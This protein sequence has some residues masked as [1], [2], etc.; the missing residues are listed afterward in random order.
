MSGFWN[1]AKNRFIYDTLFTGNGKTAEQ[2]RAEKE[3]SDEVD[4]NIE[5]RLKMSDEE[6]AAEDAFLDAYF[7]RQEEELARGRVIYN[8]RKAKEFIQYLIASLLVCIPLGYLAYEKEASQVY[9]EVT[10]LKIEP[11]LAGYWEYL[12]HPSMTGIIAF[13]IIIRLMMLVLKVLYAFSPFNDHVTIMN[14]DLGK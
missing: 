10:Y 8:A 2:L 7:A 3:F 6:R 9:D 1:Y 14:Q 13:I 12:S 4:A 5:R 11:S